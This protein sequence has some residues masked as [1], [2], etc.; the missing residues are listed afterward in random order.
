MQRFRKLLWPIAAALAVMA[1]IIYAFLPA[2]VEVD[3][4]TVERGLLLV[5][6]D[7]EGKTRVR[8]RYVVSAP[9]AG[10]EVATTRGH[11]LEP[12]PVHGT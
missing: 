1:L 9:L 4:A 5:T 6:V 7:R 10:Q 3:I 2:R 11:L 8:E 12:S